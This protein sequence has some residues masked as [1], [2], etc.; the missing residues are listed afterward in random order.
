[1]TKQLHPGKASMNGVISAILAKK[2]F[3]GARQILE[4]NRGFFKA[5]SEQHDISKITSGLGEEFKITENSFKIHASCRHTHHAMDLMIE[6]AA[7]RTISLEDIDRITVKTYQVAINITDN[8]NPTTVYASKFS[9]QFCV[10]LALLTSQGDLNVF[11]EK[12]LWNNDIRSLMKRVDVQVDQEID[13]MYPEKWAAKLE[14][15]LKSGETI[16]LETDFPK[17]DPENAVTSTELIEKFMK[18]ADRIS[19]TERKLFAERLLELESIVNVQEL[20]ASYD[21]TKVI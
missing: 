18:L 11:N 5:M 3:T 17:G 1:M 10:A 21:V 8:N 19:E 16:V 15:Y 9:L 14:V 20:M 13:Q 12:L 2:G 6:L 7:E 4:G